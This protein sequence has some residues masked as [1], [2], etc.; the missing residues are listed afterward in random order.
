MSPSF[1]SLSYTLAMAMTDVTDR[2]AL[3][4]MQDLIV[5]IANENNE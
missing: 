3:A 1:F 5:R 4:D 2:R